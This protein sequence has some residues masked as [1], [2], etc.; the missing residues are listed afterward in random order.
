DCSTRVAQPQS[1]NQ[2]GTTTNSQLEA[3]EVKGM[4]VHYLE[5]TEVVKNE[6]DE[7]LRIE[8]KEGESLFDVRNLA[9]LIASV[10]PKEWINIQG[11]DDNDDSEN[12]AEN[13]MAIYRVEL[14]QQEKKG[15]N[16]K[17]IG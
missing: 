1:N 4:N 2:T 13:I 17:L 8:L 16:I 12:D 9:S 5:V 11:Y 10:V 15:I 14:H 3:P 6:G 7:Y